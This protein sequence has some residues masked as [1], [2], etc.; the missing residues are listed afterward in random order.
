MRSL[1]LFTC[2]CLAGAPPIPS[3]ATTVQSYLSALEVFDH[4]GMSQ[5]GAHDAV[6]EPAARGPPPPP[7]HRDRHRSTRGFNP[8][9]HPPRAFPT[10]TVRSPALH[11]SSP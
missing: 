5:F 10:P 3:P 8:Q 11:S 9:I 2:F 7:T 6:S 4:R 1:V